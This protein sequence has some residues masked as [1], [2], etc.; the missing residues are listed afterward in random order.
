MPEW[1]VDT[2]D[3]KVWDRR[4]T[5]AKRIRDARGKELRWHD[6]YEAYKGRILAST[7]T[8]DTIVVNFPQAY[9]SNMLPSVYFTQPRLQVRPTQEA[10]REAARLMEPLTN[11]AFRRMRFARQARIAVQDMLLIGHGWLKMGWATKYGELPGPEQGIQGNEAITMVEKT[12]DRQVH[13]EPGMPFAKRIH[14]YLMLVDPAASSWEEVRWLAQMA[15]RPYQYL[16][17]DPFIKHKDRIKPGY[18]LDADQGYRLKTPTE[19]RELENEGYALTYEIWDLDS[20]KVRLLS[21]GSEAWQ[22][23]EE[24]PYSFMAGHS[25]YL[26]TAS[27]PTDDIY[28]YS[29]MMSWYQQVQEL[30]KIRTAQLD[31]LYRA[32]GKTIVEKGAIDNDELE[33]LRNP[34]EDVIVVREIDKITT[35]RTPAIDPNLYICE[36]RVKRDILDISGLSELQYGNIPGGRVTATVGLIAQKASAIRTRRIIDSIKEWMLDVGRDLSL[37]LANRMPDEQQVAITTDT[38]QDWIAIARADVQGEFLFDLDVTE[39]APLSREARQ[40]ESLDLWSALA[41][42]PESKRRRLATDML[43]AYGRTNIEAYLHPDMGPPADPS[44]ENEMMIQG[45][46]VL[47]NAAEDFELH[48]RIHADFMES[49]LFGQVATEVPAIRNIFSAHVQRT[50]A[51]ANQV[52]VTEQPKARAQGTAFSPQQGRPLAGSQPMAASQST[53]GA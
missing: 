20:K 37:M 9:I 46:E 45:I 53:G 39:M 19:Q 30:S 3:P 2:R 8:E 44:Y 12:A 50:I 41:M 47:P 52:T 7:P 6:A 43:E 17:E 22:R 15:Y 29:P 38:G 25:F 26:L 10:Y 4:L 18:V 13:F 32:R 35:L 14:P 24:W 27:D 31:G 11:F 21:E 49:E 34:L 23:D 36:D 16:M 28:P 1:K 51:L 48:L 40:K 42:V 33:K 5:V